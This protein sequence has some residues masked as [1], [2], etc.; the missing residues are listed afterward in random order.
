MKQ[1]RESRDKE[2]DH[3]EAD[4][5]TEGIQSHHHFHRNHHNK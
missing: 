4:R 5:N 2:I 1:E 3:Q